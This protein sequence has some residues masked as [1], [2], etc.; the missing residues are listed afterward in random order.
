[1]NDLPVVSQPASGHLD[2]CCRQVCISA[3]CHAGYPFP[4][5]LMALQIC[6]SVRESLLLAALAH[7]TAVFRTFVSF[8]SPCSKVGSPSR[9]PR[10]CD[11]VGLAL[12]SYV[13]HD[14]TGLSSNDVRES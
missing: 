12:L 13:W 14:S 7:A 3:I 1:M 11:D 2:Y 9:S 6:S 4:S 10:L 8:P 5:P